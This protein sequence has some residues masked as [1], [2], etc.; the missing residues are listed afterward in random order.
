[1]AVQYYIEED[2][3]VGL[4]NL[5]IPTDG[6]LFEEDDLRDLYLHRWEEY[7]NAKEKKVLSSYLS[8]THRTDFYRG[9]PKIIK[10]KL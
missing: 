2:R 10:K 8:T 6:G 7:S 3:E 5:C 1:L 9:N 4:G